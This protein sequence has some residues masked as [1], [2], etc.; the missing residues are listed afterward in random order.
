MSQSAYKSV[1][2][3]RKRISGAA[4][5][6]AARGRVL[7]PGDDAIPLISLRECRGLRAASPLSAGTIHVRPAIRTIASAPASLQK[8]LDSEFHFTRPSLSKARSCNS[9]GCPV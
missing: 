7:F 5:V 3:T 4:F 8:I 9:R 6:K 1:V 2:Q